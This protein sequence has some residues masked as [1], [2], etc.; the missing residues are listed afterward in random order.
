MSIIP[1]ACATPGRTS[2]GCAAQ[3]PD[4][5]VV[6]EKILERDEELRADWAVAGT[7]G[8]DFLN[9]VTGLFIDPAGEKPLTDALCASSAVGHRPFSEVVYAEKQRI[10]RDVLASEFNRLIEYLVAVVRGNRRNRDFGRAQLRD[11]VRE[12]VAASPCTERT[13]AP[14]RARSLPTD[15]QYVAQH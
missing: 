10:L 12:V 1:T 9:H 8:Y 3:P 2:T 11:A 15:R 13:C 5:W 4:A 7:T 6:A 14:K